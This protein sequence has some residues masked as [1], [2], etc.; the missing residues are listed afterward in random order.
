[1]E[2]CGTYL[3]GAREA[4][5]ISLDEI[6]RAT[7]IR[8]S[9]LEAIER[10]QGDS[11][12][13]EV[14]VKGFIEIYAR[15]VGVD[16]EEALSRYSQRQKDGASA[17]KG[18]ARL[19]GKQE[20]LKR[21]IISGAALCVVLCGILLLFLVGGSKEEGREQVM[22]EARPEQEVIPPPAQLQPPSAPS[23]KEILPLSTS[24]APVQE[25]VVTEES[26]PVREHALVITATERTWVQIQ[27]GTSLPF[28]VVLYPGES[29]T[30]TSPHQLA[31]VIGNAGG[32]TVTF[33]GKGLGSLGKVG[34][35]VRLT[36]PAPEEG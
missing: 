20:A 34:E 24:Q 6:T 28:D 25:D 10:D 15:H 18:H 35:V 9:I 2:S 29:Y 16:P 36:L 23:E 8:R 30:R 14:V 11:L 5:K 3:K 27:E 19:E 4:K 13:P 31:V 12:L 21:Y 33:D 32:V 26:S 1:M 22:T 17:D 7:K